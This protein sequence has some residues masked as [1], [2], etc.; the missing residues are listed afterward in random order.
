MESNAMKKLIA[1]LCLSTLIIFSV[2]IYEY[3]PRNQLVI[4]AGSSSG[5]FHQ[6]AKILQDQLLEKYNIQVSIKQRDDTL[7]IL[8]DVNNPNSDVDVGF[9]AQNIKIK[10]HENVSSLG[11]IGV[12][13]LLIFKRK[14]SKIK[15]F[16]DLKGKRLG[17]QPINNGTRVVADE[18]LSAFGIDEKNSS[19][20]SLNILDSIKA[21]EGNQIDAAF[22][23]MP[24]KTKSILKLAENPEFE[25]LG[26]PHPEAVALHLKYLS[27]VKVHQ[28]TFSLSPTLPST[29]IHTI[30]V[31]IT[32]IAKKDINPAHAIAIAT[33]LKTEAGEGDLITQN[34]AFPSVFTVKGLASNKYANEIYENESGYLPILYHY[35]P[36]RLAGFL[37]DTSTL[38]GILLSFFLVHNFLGL[39]SLYEAIRRRHLK[40]D[41]PEIEKLVLKLKDA[42]LS[43]NELNKIKNFIKVIDDFPETFTSSAQRIR[44]D[45]V[46]QKNKL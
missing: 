12:E 36:F 41:L 7:N 27:L 33:I 32:V 5:Y 8:S 30:G 31:P 17:V 23:L 44:E 21:L 4:M 15:N 43:E 9:I 45:F 35:L 24:A 1:Y 13:P 2:A 14:N 6:L 3:W 19:F 25:L 42:E 39:P 40:K 34:D 10:N 16:R 28:G 26:I 38:L 29:D 11:S 22:F 46:A 18:V 37:T 20:L